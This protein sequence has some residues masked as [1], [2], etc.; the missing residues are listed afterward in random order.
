[1]VTPTEPVRV[2]KWSAAKTW[3]AATGGLLTVATAVFADDA[4]DSSE[5]PS[6]I[7]GLIV[8]ALTVWR[9]Y[10]TPNKPTQ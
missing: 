3:V 8:A 2:V 9:V 10:Q 4:M 7:G 1:M 5:V 6:V